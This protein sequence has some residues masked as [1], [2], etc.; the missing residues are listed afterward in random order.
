M[1]NDGEEAY[2]YLNNNNIDPFLIISDIN[3]PKMLGTE[4]RD[5]MQNEGKLRL[6]TVPFLFLTTSAAKDNIIDALAHS[7]QSFFLKA[8]NFEELKRTIKRILDYWTE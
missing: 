8:Q 7:V 6:R 3:M 4:L 5:K 1:L 2:R